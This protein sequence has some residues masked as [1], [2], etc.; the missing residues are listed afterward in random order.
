M[1]TISKEKYLQVLLGQLQHL[2]GIE[3]TNPED[4]EA[5]VHAI[6]HANQLDFDEVEVIQSGPSF[7]FKIV[8]KK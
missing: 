4:L 5:L 8:E 7:T 3:T 6:E 2:R 1:K